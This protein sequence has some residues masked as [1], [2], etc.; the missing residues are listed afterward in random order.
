M[1]P[2]SFGGFV[3]SAGTT[4]ALQVRNNLTST[5]VT[6]ASG[7]S[8]TTPYITDA[9]GQTYYAWQVHATVPQGVQHWAQTGGWNPATNSGTI[10]SRVRAMAGDTQLPTLPLGGFQCALEE[11]NRT[12]SGEAA[13]AA[14]KTATSEVEL[15]SPCGDY[16]KNCCIFAPSC[17]A[18][19]SCYSF[20]AANSVAKCEP[21]FLPP[22][23]NSSHPSYKV[24]AEG[25]QG[26]T[27]DASHWYFTNTTSIVKIPVSTNLASATWSGAQV[28]FPAYAHYG[29]PCFY[30]GRVFVP[31]EQGPG[32][33]PLAIGSVNTSLGSPVVIPL[34]GAVSSPWC[35]AHAGVLYTSDFNSGVIRRY[36]IVGSQLTRISDLELRGHQFEKPFVVERIQGGAVSDSGKTLFISSDQLRAVYAFDLPTGALRTVLVL[37]AGS[38]GT[39][40]DPEIEGMTFW[41][42]PAAPGV[43]G[44]LHVIDLINRFPGVDPFY[45]YNL[46][47][48]DVSRL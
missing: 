32:S 14:C 47:T 38:Q 31:L 24:F 1:F 46:H 6:F 19:A 39:N 25:L 27:H 36:S 8:E 9:T 48:S 28:P 16:A 45:M 15:Y 22:F 10:R 21:D 29:D 17:R 34:S 40:E 11:Y 2:T 3:P 20:D 42:S 35:A 43:T 23:T 13:I 18:G 4:V 33:A 26:V 41:D 7:A 37:P 5:W 44:Q 12:G 30:N